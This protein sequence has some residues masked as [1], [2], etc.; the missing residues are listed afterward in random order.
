MAFYRNSGI[1]RLKDYKQ[2]LEWHDNTKP[3][4]GRTPE[5]RPLGKRVNTWYQIAVGENQEVICK[6]Y[7]EPVVIFHSNGEIELKDYIYRTTSTA[8]FIE[9]VLGVRAYI[10]DKSLIVFTGGVE[11]KQYR[12]PD[13][14]EG[15]GIFFV[16]SENYHRAINYVRGGIERHSHTINRKAKKEMLLKHKPLFDYVRGMVKLREGELFDYSANKSLW[17]NDYNNTNDPARSKDFKTYLTTIAEC[18]GDTNPDTKL[19]SWTSLINVLGKDFGTYHYRFEGKMLNH[20]QAMHGLEV[21]LMG[22]HRD[23]VFD[24]K[25]IE[26]GRV[27]RDRYAVYWS[28]GWNKFHNND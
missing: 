17:G 6:Q 23:T 16:R 1:P 10:H 5:L 20:E 27:K 13:P 18:I 12:V 15:D 9:E 21:I 28:G 11:D 22:I 8:H 4:R 24:K 25:P 7:G 3:I 2:A 14:K 26:N 19:E